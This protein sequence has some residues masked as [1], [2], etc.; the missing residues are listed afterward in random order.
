MLNS[1]FC[2][3]F[4]ASILAVVATAQVQE[5][6]TVLKGAP[7][8]SWSVESTDTLVPPFTDDFSYPS[9][10]PS[11]ALWQDAKVWVNDEMALFQNSLGVATFD[12]LNE[13][14][15]AYKENALGSDSLADVLTSAYLD[16]QGLSNVYLSFQLQ[17]GGRGE[18]PSNNDSIVVEYWSPVTAD[19]TQVWG[20]KGS[21]TSGPFSSVILPVQGANYLQKG[22]RFRFAAYGARAGAYDIWNVDYVQLDKDRNPSDTIITEPAIAR[23]H[24]LIIGSGAYTSWP[25]WVSNASSVANRPS[26]LEFIYR[27]NGAV[28]SGGWSLNLG[29]FRWEENG[30]LFNRLQQCR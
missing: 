14:G 7:V 11:A 15:F 6:T 22:F 8:T 19:W 13:Y 29:Q 4:F 2:F 1:R 26:T 10:K 21:G 5:I 20:Q 23:A 28:P 25:W 24:P 12:G 30:A 3:T 27:R 16:L 17:E 9:D 18:L